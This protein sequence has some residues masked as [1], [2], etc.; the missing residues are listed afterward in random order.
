MPEPAS[1]GPGR[2][3]VAPVPELPEVES[4]RRVLAQ[5]ALGRRIVDVD[6]HDDYVT[7]PHAPGELRSALVGRCFA[8]ARRRGKS[9]W[10]TTSGSGD[11]GGP[12]LGVHLGMSGIVAVTPPDGTGAPVGEP[13]GDLSGDLVGGDY[14][15][16]RERFVARGEYQRFAVTFADGGGVRLLDPRRLSRVRLDPDIEALGPDALG[17]SP[18]AFRAAM[19][20]GRRVSTAPVKARLLDQSVIAG[21][22][23]LLADEALWRARIGPARGVDTLRRADVDRLGRSLQSALTDAVERG[24]V[25]TGTVIAFRRAGERCPRCGGS[26][27]SGTVGGRTTWWCSRE[28]RPVAPS[29]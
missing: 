2:R 27:V 19:T 14:R 18:A 26:M 24:G 28:Q 17:L 16:D 11:D 4:A 15:R 25:H 1:P 13:A 5:G 29:A 6:D 10:L 23:N 22:G 3:T 7:R 21:V 12:D 8:A 20:A 9:M